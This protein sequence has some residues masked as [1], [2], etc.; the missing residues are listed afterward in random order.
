MFF[1]QEGFTYRNFLMD[2]IAIFAFVVWF[3]LLIVIY[4]DLF[5]RH[6]ISGWGKALWVLVL[7]LT[8]YLGIFAYLI[9][10]G[11]S[12]AERNAEQAQRAREELRHIVG[13]S[14]ADELTKLD[15][16]RK[17]GSVTDDEYRRLRTRLVS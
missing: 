8:S 14:V 7:V 6:D 4:G 12:M 10:Q 2:M 13:F 16:L 15:Q 11:R 3:W 9:T 1:V 17:A 5:R